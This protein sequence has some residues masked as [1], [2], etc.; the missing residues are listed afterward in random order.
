MLC[1]EAVDLLS[2]GMGKKVKDV[3]VCTSLNFTLSA[4]LHVAVTYH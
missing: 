1:M 3:M 2:E 4:L